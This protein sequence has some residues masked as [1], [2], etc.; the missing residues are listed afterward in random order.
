VSA[1]AAAAAPAPD[2]L[3][4]K[5]KGAGGDELGVDPLITSIPSPLQSEPSEPAAAPIET[6]GTG[7]PASSVDSLVGSLCSCNQRLKFQRERIWLRTVL[8]ARVGGVVEEVGLAVAAAAA[9]GEVGR[10]LAGAA[11]AAVL[12][13]ARWYVTGSSRRH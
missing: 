3:T 13:Q 4:V 5:E 11:V 8:V 2:F 1:G 9:V 7:E 12:H 10:L 6:P